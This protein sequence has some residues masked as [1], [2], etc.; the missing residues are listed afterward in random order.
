MPARS[1]CH[2]RWW[3]G[4]GP[5]ALLKPG[6]DAW[7]TYNGDY[8]GRRYSPLAEINASNIGGLALAWF[9][10]CVG[11]QRGVEI[12]I[13]STPLMVNGIFYHHPGSRLGRGRPDWRRIWH[14]WQD[15]GGHLWANRGLGMYG[16]WL[17]FMTPDCWFLSLNAKDGKERWRKK[18]ADER[19]STSAPRPHGGESHSGGRGRRRWPD[20]P[21]RAIRDRDCTG[22]GIRR[23]AR[24]SPG[25]HRAESTS[26]GHGGHDLMPGT[27]DPS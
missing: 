9:I 14:G 25:R 1:Q 5:R 6:A 20:S 8:S 2:S 4:A 7:P 11:A 3:R 17:Y 21:S 13:T 10:G 26:H 27:Y 23:R 22:D 12:Q 19:C 24:V 16:E 18:V 15:K